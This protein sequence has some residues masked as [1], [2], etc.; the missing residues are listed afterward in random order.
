MFNDP[1]DLFENN[2]ATAN[3]LLQARLNNLQQ[4]LRK[5]T[6]YTRQDYQAEVY[7]A[8]NAVL[9]L[10]NNMTPLNL[11]VPETPAIIGD[12]ETNLDTLNDD[13]QSI[14]AQVTD[15]ESQASELYNLCAMTQ[16]SLRQQV[17]ENLLLP[18]SQLYI[19]PFLNKNNLD[20]NKTTATLDY[21]TGLATLPLISETA[22][23]PDRI[24]IG[25]SSSG[26]MASGST[27]N[28]MINAA[29]GTIMTW[30]GPVLELRLEFDTPQIINRLYL[31]QDNYQGLYL[32]ELTC[33]DTGSNQDNIK[34]DLQ[35]SQFL[36]NAS[37]GKFSGNVI[38]D[39]PP[40]TISELRII[41]QD[42]TGQ[43]L[44][45]LRGINAAQRLYDTQAIIQSNSISQPSNTVYFNTI[46]NVSTPLVTITHLLSYDNVHFQVITPGSE[47][48]L[49]SSPFWY[50]GS[51]NRMTNI[52]ELSGPLLT[53]TDPG[54]NTNYVL[55]SSTTINVGANVIQRNL[56]F[57]S[58]TGP[59]VLLD[60]PLP[61]TFVVYQ[62]AIQLPSTA[63]TF[64]DNTL[65]FP[66]PIQNVSIS[67]Q[68]SSTGT[69]GLQSRL[70]YFSPFLYE[71]S[72]EAV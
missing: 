13:A 10:N 7:S 5:L 36:L 43:N 35:E 62:G 24:E 27:A 72:F 39:F 52:S 71:F 49:A 63:Y 19:E 56:S 12:L 20:T 55:T 69:A 68:T 45:A 33:S 38:L 26:S 53:T 22:I 64:N 42:M 37:S 48:N 34:T 40:R 44:I 31:I 4:T 57:S 16:N 9:N 17:R 46:Q 15:L 60:D 32:Q 61:G 70:Q 29:F 67:Y 28:S 58:V 65:I 30:N 50:Q 23:V 54:L 3:A 41:L 59:I 6:Y 25:P 51:F 8:L 47:I 1:D 66:A 21:A 11:I 14:V 2:S 18:T